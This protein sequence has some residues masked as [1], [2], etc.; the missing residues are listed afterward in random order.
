LEVRKAQHVG[1]DDTIQK[2]K[3][4]IVDLQ[5]KLQG[6]GSVMVA[7]HVIPNETKMKT[8]EQEKEINKLKVELVE[9]KKELN[10]KTNELEGKEK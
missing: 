5:E 10:N 3:S 9:V 4:T 1:C 2:L 8:K 7:I 6:L